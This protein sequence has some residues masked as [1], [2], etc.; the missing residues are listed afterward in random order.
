VSAATKG[1][2][3][4][5]SVCIDGDGLIQLPASTIIEAGTVLAVQAGASLVLGERNTIYPNCSFR[6]GQGTLRTGRDVSFGPGVV[7][8]EPR[9]GISIGDHCLIAAGVMMCGAGHQFTALDLPIRQQPMWSAPITIEADVWLGM[10]VILL[11]GVQIGRGAVIGAGSVVTQSIPAAVVAY[12]SPCKPRRCR[13]GTP[14]P[15]VC[16]PGDLP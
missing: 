8:Y 1:G 11:P 16:P 10:G 12:G 2:F 6:L 15:A 7:I 9:G 5:P 14:L 3:I 13:D 4:H